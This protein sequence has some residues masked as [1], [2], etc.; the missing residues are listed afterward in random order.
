MLDPTTSMALRVAPKWTPDLADKIQ[1]L[2]TVSKLSATEIADVLSR[3]DRV[4]FSRNS[5]IG[6]LHRLG[7]TRPKTERSPRDPSH[8]PR[9]KSASVMLKRIESRRTNRKTLTVAPA[10]EEAFLDIT[11]IELTRETCR[12]PRGGERNAL[13]TTFC[14]QK[15]LGD[16]P[17]CPYH[18]GLAYAKPWERAA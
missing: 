18:F 2:W 12:W 10:C 17:Y 8:R 1:R 14:G 5:V 11:L 9:M 13:E 16:H 3:E 6:K 15:P 4:S 7:L